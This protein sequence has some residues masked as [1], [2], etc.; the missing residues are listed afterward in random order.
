MSNRTADVYWQSYALAGRPDFLNY[1]PPGIVTWDGLW[2]FYRGQGADVQSIVRLMG[3]FHTFQ[4]PR[5]EEE[6]SVLDTGGTVYPRLQEWARF[7]VDHEQLTE[8]MV[9]ENLADLLERSL[10]CPLYY[11]AAFSVYLE[12]T[13]RH[14]ADGWRPEMTRRVVQEAPLAMPV[15]ERHLSLRVNELPHPEGVPETSPTWNATA[16]AVMARTHD[17]WDRSYAEALGE[18]DPDWVD[19]GGGD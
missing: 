1:L 2:S 3:L 16:T 5:F 17:A 15:V 19:V 11:E 4:S 8:E 6:G 13:L 7:A 12:A 18:E 9:R 14:C 10:I